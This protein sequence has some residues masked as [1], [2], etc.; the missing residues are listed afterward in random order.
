MEEF[1]E[2]DI[3]WPDGEHDDDTVSEKQ[4]S[5]R[6]QHRRKQSAPVVI[7]MAGVGASRSWAPR[8]NYRD[9]YHNSEDVDDDDDDDFGSGSGGERTPPHIIVARRTST[10]KMAFSVCVGKGRTLKGRDLYQVR[11]AILRMTGFLE[12]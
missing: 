7:P 11:N 3:L 2:T 4:P 5:T 1:Q 9:S 10:E 12:R 8:C 6:E